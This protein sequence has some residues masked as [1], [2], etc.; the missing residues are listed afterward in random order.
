MACTL[1]SDLLERTVFMHLLK[2][3]PCLWPVLSS[4]RVEQMTKTY[5]DM[6]VVTQL[7][8]EVGV[9]SLFIVLLFKKNQ[10]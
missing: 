1:W 10:M 2:E 5:N 7:L 3:N 8:A 9:R 6:E 4:D